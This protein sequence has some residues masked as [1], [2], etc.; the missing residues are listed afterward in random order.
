[1]Q[2]LRYFPLLLL[3]AFML[4]ILGCNTGDHARQAASEPLPQVVDYNFHIRPILS[5]R[6]YA[7]HGPDAHKREAGLRLDTEAGAKGLLAETRHRAVVPGKLE[8]SALWYRIS[9]EDPEERM[10]PPAS[11]LSLNE[12]E[13]LLLK[14]WIEQGA[15]W[16]PHWAFMPPKMPDIPVVKHKDWPKN[17]IDYF[18]LHGMESKGLSPSPEASREQLIRRLSFDLR[19]LPPTLE[20][21][22]AFLAD[23]SA[24]AYSRL[25]DRFLA[26]SAFG[27]RMAIDWLDLARYADSHGYQDDLERSMW[28]WRDWVIRAFNRNMPYD[29]FLTCQ[30]AGDLLPTPTYEQVLATGFNRNHKITQEVGVID[31]EYRVEY[32]VDRTNTFSAAFMGLTME[33]ARCHD[34]KYDPFTQKEYYQLFSFF[35]NIDEKGRVDY[36]VEV[37]EPTLELPE[38]TVAAHQTFIH[39]LIAQQAA[40]LRQYQEEKLQQQPVVMRIRN[41]PSH[42]KLPFSPDLYFHLD[43]LRDSSLSDAARGKVRARMGGMP[44]PVKGKYGGGADFNGQN[45]LELPNWPAIRS[46]RGFSISM[47]I[48]SPDGG[49]RGTLVAQTTVGDDHYR[50]FEC[51]ITNPK[52]VGARITGS[53][54][55]NII[56]ETHEPVPADTWMHM[57]LVYDGSGSAEGMNFYWNGELQKKIVKRDSLR[58]S[59][60]NREPLRIAKRTDRKGLFWGQMDELMFFSRALKPEEIQSLGKYDPLAEIAQNA[61]EERTAEEQQRLLIHQ[62]YQQDVHFLQL[63][64]R[65]REYQIRN[66]RLQDVV[67]KPTMVMKE[68]E[69]PRPA[70]V[71]VR[72]QYDQ[73]AERVFPGTPAAILPFDSTR[74]PPNRLGLAQWLLSEQHPLTARVAVNRFWQMVFGRGMVKTPEDF[75][76]QGALPSHPAL[77]DWLAV[78]FRQG[79]WDVKKLMKLMVMSATYRQ[80]SHVTPRL[81]RLDPQNQWLARGPRY[82]LPAEM[83]RDQAL[84]VS[85]LLNRKM[86]GPSVKP[87]QP[88]GLWLAAASGNQP[89]RKYIQDHGEN[90]YRRSIYTFWKRTVPPPNMITFD[91]ATRNQCVLKRQ[92]TSTPLQ[93]LVLLNDPQFVEASRLLAQRMIDEGGHD[94]RERLSLGFRLVTSRFPSE[95]ALGLLED[96]LQQELANFGQAPGHAEKLLHTGEYPLPDHVGPAELAAYTVVANV[97]LNMVE[98]VTQS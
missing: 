42:N 88:P 44:V 24:D 55:A 96:M 45:F 50:G 93:A 71:L 40:K 53:K 43:D 90:L 26:D 13:K 19:G 81:Q 1:M 87:Y 10:P 20:E 54:N 7:C 11:N 57:V 5:D 80:R 4:G 31:E 32:V 65:L 98:S 16:K 14:K 66:V 23:K 25:V 47:W 61:R 35:N 29:S 84:A 94:A 58:G 39:K 97:L 18:V 48:R 91:A 82:R 36:N 22:D 74:Y 30:L 46:R 78:S 17:A 3:G 89:L 92:A 8:E 95:E 67:L 9:H 76:S 33:C 79:G 64:E 27:E 63:S 38:E 75:G 62:L 59:A 85:G 41:A 60:T 12:R 37:A 69:K 28:P 86:G 49:A 77:L 6:C 73:P 51:Y 68:M 83:I 70:F 15:E 34:H 21:M 56:V 72:G 2:K 52:R